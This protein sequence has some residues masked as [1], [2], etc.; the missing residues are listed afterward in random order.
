MVNEI[1]W[2]LIFRAPKNFMKRFIAAHC[3]CTVTYCEGHA[4]K[5]DIR[6]LE[7]GS[8]A[9]FRIQDKMSHDS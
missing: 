9:G 7:Y 5:V 2:S 6:E 3:E 8:V 1:I 4:R